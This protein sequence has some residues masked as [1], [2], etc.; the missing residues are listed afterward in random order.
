MSFV[1]EGTNNGGQNNPSTQTQP[2]P[3]SQPPQ[4]PQYIKTQTINEHFTLEV[5]ARNPNKSEE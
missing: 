1:D 2:T 4:P 3:S 5:E